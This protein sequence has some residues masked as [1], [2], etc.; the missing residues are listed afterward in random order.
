MGNSN[1]M[2]EPVRSVS[3]AFESG[4]LPLWLRAEF[5][6]WGRKCWFRVP[7]T[8][9][10]LSCSTWDSRR[11]MLQAPGF[12]HQGLRGSALCC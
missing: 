11:R 5:V 8:M 2:F 12:E 4:V 6:F 1:M 9:W 3:L 7:E 10:P